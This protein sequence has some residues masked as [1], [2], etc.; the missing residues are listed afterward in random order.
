M[1][2]VAPKISLNKSKLTVDWGRSQVQV[3]V[4]DAAALAKI[5]EG[6]GL[7]VGTEEAADSSSAQDTDPSATKTSSRKRRKSR[8]NVGDALVIWMSAYPG[9]HSEEK[10]LTTVIAHRMS[11][12]E[13]KRALKIA[14]GR[15]KGE[16]FVTDGLGN[17]QLKEDLDQAHKMKHFMSSDTVEDTSRWDS[18]SAQEIARARR[19]LL[20]G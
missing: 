11:D 6:I 9:W 17:W 1:D 18:S 15:K 8:K 19:N 3:H 12:A 5:L 2:N 4:D 20:G 14:L 7:L 13:P 16:V 10:L